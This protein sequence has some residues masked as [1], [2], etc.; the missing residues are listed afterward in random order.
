MRGPLAGAL[1]PGFRGMTRRG[2]SRRD[3]GAPFSGAIGRFQGVARQFSAA[4]RDPAV[5][6]RASGC[7]RAGRAFDQ[8]PFPIAGA[9]ALQPPDGPCCLRAGAPPLIAQKTG[10]C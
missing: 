9:T 1:D 6:G 10:D 5:A 3:W 8:T 2:T 4:W 7:G